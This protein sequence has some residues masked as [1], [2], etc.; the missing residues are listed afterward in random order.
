MYDLCVCCV[1]L[2]SK[3]NA[4]QPVCIVSSQTFYSYCVLDLFM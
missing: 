3:L 2:Q 1:C 4:L